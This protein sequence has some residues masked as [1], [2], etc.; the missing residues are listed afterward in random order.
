MSLGS[1]GGRSIFVTFEG[2]GRRVVGYTFLW[3]KSVHG[4]DAR[5]HCAKC[6]KGTFLKPTGDWVPP[7]NVRKEYVLAPKAKAL[8]ICGVSRRGYAFNLHAPCQPDD[9]APPLVVPMTDDQ[10]L[11]IEQATLMTIPS[12]PNGWNGLPESYTSC[13][14][15]AWACSVFGW[16][17]SQKSLTPD[18]ERDR[19]RGRAERNGET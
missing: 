6:L 7:L 19:Y 18:V 16:P 12:V 1:Q 13:R 8:Y 10:R 2:H 15:W 3:I 11:V 14:N 9:S 5:F 4:F 17:A